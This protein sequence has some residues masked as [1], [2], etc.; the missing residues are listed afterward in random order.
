MEWQACFLFVGNLFIQQTVS[1]HLP[2]AY[3]P[4]RYVWERQEGPNRV[5]ALKN[6]QR[7]EPITKMRGVPGER[8]EEGAQVS[9]GDE[10]K[11]EGSRL[12]R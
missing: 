12:G 11:V 8:E 10:R 9:A 3:L 5:L 2:R 7:R 6:T 1:E 4:L